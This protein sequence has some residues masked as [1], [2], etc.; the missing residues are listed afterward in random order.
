MLP[1]LCKSVFDELRREPAVMWSPPLEQGHREDGIL[2]MHKRQMPP[3]RPSER[4]GVGRQ[5]ISRYHYRHV[6]TRL[7]C[8]SGA[9][10][11]KS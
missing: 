5:Y 7:N 11:A 8:L 6:I 3:G 10:G 1:G 9:K 4:H 2:C